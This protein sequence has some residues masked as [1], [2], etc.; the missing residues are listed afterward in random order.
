[1]PML[2]HMAGDMLGT[3]EGAEQLESLAKAVEIE[4]LRTE[5]RDL[6]PYNIV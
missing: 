4:L 6:G 2:T 3:G 5:V 1:M